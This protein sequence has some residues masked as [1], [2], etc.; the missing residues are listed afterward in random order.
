MLT[1]L[2]EYNYIISG[3]QTENAWHFWQGFLFLFLHFLISGGRC[4]DIGEQ[5]SSRPWQESDGQRW[6]CSSEIPTHQHHGAVLGKI[7]LHC[8]RASFPANT[9]KYREIP[10]S[11]LSLSFLYFDYS[12]AP[13]AVGS[14]GLVNHDSY[15]GRLSGVFPNCLSPWNIRRVVKLM[16]FLFWMEIKRLCHMQTEMQLSTKWKFNLSLQCGLASLVCSSFYFEYIS[17]SISTPLT[18]FFF[19]L[20]FTVSFSSFC[21]RQQK[22]SCL[23][24]WSCSTAMSYA[25]IPSCPSLRSLGP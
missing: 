18:A 25:L 3:K 23:E 20:P 7:W 15:Y 1:A 16:A 2:V 24:C 8:S 4:Y 14:H 5:R 11:W 19:I 21:L 6:W 22:P 10:L 9:G 17:P 13:Y 12:M